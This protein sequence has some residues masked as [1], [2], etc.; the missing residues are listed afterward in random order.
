MEL[1]TLGRTGIR[2]TPAG[3]GV[4]TVGRT[5]L[6]L[7]IAEGAGIV[8]YALECGINFLD[9]A[10]YYETY[11]YIAAA[12]KGFDGRPVI[13]SKSLAA[14]Y[15]G[16][17]K[18]IEDMRY[19][20]DLDVIDLFLLHEIRGA[21]D[22]EVRSGAWACLNDLKAKGIVRAIG[23]STHHVDAAELNAGLAESDILFP[24]INKA[25][26]GIR[27]KDGF[28]T[29]E[30]MAAAIAQNSAAGKGVFTMKV[31]GGGN[32]TGDYLSALD[33]VHGLPGVDSIMVGIGHEEEIDRLIEYFEGKIDRNYVPDLHE[34][35]IRIDSGD[36][37]GCGACLARCPNKAIRMTNTHAAE[38]DHA[39]CLTCGYCA[40]VCPV[41]AII[42]F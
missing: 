6:N 8:R 23:L 17:A 15:S 2:V 37:E 38:V 9:T 29:K 30:A 32:L 35:R 4:L 16:M 34:K 25:G 7:S 12:L 24:L 1:K 21:H 22:F 11:P 19:A 40:P 13:A 10:E 5:Q 42:M 31:F 26:L 27:Y 33:Y 41:R 14:S 3:M 39:I 20:L 18:A 36:C 28:G